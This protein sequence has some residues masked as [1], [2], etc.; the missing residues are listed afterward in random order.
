MQIKIFQAV[1]EN[2]I[3]IWLKKNPYI[4]AVYVNRIPMFD[5]FNDGEICNQW[6]DTV[7]MYE[8]EASID[9]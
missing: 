7:I 9:E 1:E 6:T 3:N 8:I 5:R 2:D 4:K